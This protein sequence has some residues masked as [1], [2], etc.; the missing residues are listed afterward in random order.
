MG[1]RWNGPRLRTRHQEV[2]MSRDPRP[3]IFSDFPPGPSKK[4]ASHAWPFL[5]FHKCCGPRALFYNK[6]LFLLFLS[7]FWFFSFSLTLKSSSLTL[8]R[9]KNSPVKTLEGTTTTTE[10]WEFDSVLMEIC[11]LKFFKKQGICDRIFFFE[12]M[13]HKMAKFGHQR[14]GTA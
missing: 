5:E 13:F 8:F 11:F 7:F 4:P 6:L 12:N 1:P 14:K 9:Q 2:V 10:K 3:G